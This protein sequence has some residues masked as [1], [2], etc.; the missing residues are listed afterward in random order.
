MNYQRGQGSG[1]CRLW[2][3]L[4]KARHIALT[5]LLVRMQSFMN[6]CRNLY[7]T[8]PPDHWIILLTSKPFNY[9]Q[10][11][12]DE[13]CCVFY[14]LESKVK[15]VAELCKHFGSDT[16]SW[17]VLNLQFFIC[18][19]Y[20]RWWEE[21][22]IYFGVVKSKFYVTNRSRTLSTIWF[23]HNDFFVF[24]ATTLGGSLSDF[25]SD[26]VYHCWRV[27]EAQDV[28][29]KNHRTYGS[30]SLRMSVRPSHFNLG[31]MIETNLLCASASILASISHDARINRIRGTLVGHIAI[32]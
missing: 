18:C 16:I 8:Y 9:F 26:I 28:V 17:I 29:L 3:G 14:P 6:G 4:D 12:R 23:W 5:A 21:D 10:A 22:S 27:E 31:N 1:P 15:V 11:R 32:E 7:K 30:V 19:T 25:V 13:I 20:A 24:Y 2:R